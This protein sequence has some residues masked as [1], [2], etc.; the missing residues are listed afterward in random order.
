MKE[1]AKKKSKIRDEMVEDQEIQNLELF[2]KENSLIDSDAS[3][4][5]S[6]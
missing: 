2:L 1:N 6:A 5:E 4:S 3:G